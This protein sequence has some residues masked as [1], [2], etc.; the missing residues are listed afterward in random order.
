M[1]IVRWIKELVE[2]VRWDIAALR[3]LPKL[4]DELT[5]EDDLW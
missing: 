4:L 1:G 5:R 2:Q 3:E